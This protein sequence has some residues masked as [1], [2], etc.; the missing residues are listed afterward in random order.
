MTALTETE[1][2]GGSSARWQANAASLTRGGVLAA[3][4]A[5]TVVVATSPSNA[6]SGRKRL[7]ESLNR[8]EGQKF[9][10]VI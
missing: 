1:R 3:A 9:H 2:F 10:Y 4:L 8:P 6:M 5:I 7:I